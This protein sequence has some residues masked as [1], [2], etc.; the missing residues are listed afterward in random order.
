MEVNYLRDACGLSRMNSESNESIYTEGLYTYYGE[1]MS[2]RLVEMVK[3]STLR[4]FGE[5]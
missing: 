5:E 3:S 2:C 4:G 1:E